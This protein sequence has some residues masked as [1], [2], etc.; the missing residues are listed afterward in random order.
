LLDTKGIWGA[1]CRLDDRNNY[2]GFSLQETIPIVLNSLVENN[3]I[4]EEDTVALLCLLLPDYS[5]HYN[6]LV[7]VLLQKIRS[8]VP[9]RQKPMLE[10]LSHDILYN[11][12]MNEKRDRSSNMVS[13]LD[14]VVLSPNIDTKRIRNMNDFL[15]QHTFQNPEYEK[16][17]IN[18]DNQ[19]NTKQNILKKDITS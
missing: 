8:L 5:Y 7:D 16:R 17:I 14:S 18:R 13:Y 6:E 12:P 10:I 1:I 2:D 9:E 19:P 15:Q 11:I 4:S 3:L